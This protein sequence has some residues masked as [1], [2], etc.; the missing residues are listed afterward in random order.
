MKVCSSCPCRP[1][2]CLQGLPRYPRGSTPAFA[3]RSRRRAMGSA[4]APSE[5]MQQQL[6][7]INS[8]SETQIWSL[9]FHPEAVSDRI[10]R[11]ACGNLNNQLFL[12]KVRASFEELQIE[13]FFITN[14][15]YAMRFGASGRMES[16][17]LYLPR[18]RSTRSKS[19]SDVMIQSSSVCRKFAEQT[20]IQCYWQTQNTG[21]AMWQSEHG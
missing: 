16:H 5:A 15:Q 10:F 8:V 4:L 2:L 21:R 13:D 19:L 9:A 6:K 11:D 18:S 3:L 14:K 7:A 20:F 12:C 1:S 17:P